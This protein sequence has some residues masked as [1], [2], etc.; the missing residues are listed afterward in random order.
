MSNTKKNK[1]IPNIQIINTDLHW[2]NTWKYHEKAAVKL[3]PDPHDNPRQTTSDVIQRIKRAK[4]L[5]EACAEA[6]VEIKTVA[7]VLMMRRDKAIVDGQTATY[8]DFN[9][10][11]ETNFRVLIVRG[12]AGTGK[13]QY[14]LAHFESALLVSHMDDLRN[15]DK[16]RHDGIVL[17]WG[18][19]E[20]LTAAFS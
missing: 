14:A 19:G 7:D 8:H 11:L 16:E 10:P 9:V 18:S 13:T 3:S 4:T 15:F 2:D 12:K 6:G 1:F 5:H 20:S 17:S